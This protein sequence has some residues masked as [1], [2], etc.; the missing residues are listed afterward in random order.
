MSAKQR[1]RALW[2]RVRETAGV[3]ANAAATPRGVAPSSY[4]KGV[5]GGA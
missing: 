2:G 5:D 4:R 1:A 3:V